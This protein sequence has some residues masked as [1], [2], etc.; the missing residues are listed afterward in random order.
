MSQCIADTNIP[1]NISE[2]I[3]TREMRMTRLQQHP[4]LSKISAEN[5]MSFADNFPHKQQNQREWPPGGRLL[6]LLNVSEH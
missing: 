3:S 1:L 2:L 6:H 5:A 4:F